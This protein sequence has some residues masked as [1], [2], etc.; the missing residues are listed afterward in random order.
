M[1]W[2]IDEFDLT[3]RKNEDTAWNDDK[4]F[5]TTQPQHVM[6]VWKKD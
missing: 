2:Y 5:L 6:V 1:L 4:V 3:E